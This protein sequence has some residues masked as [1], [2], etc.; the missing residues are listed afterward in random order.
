MLEF[1]IDIHMKRQYSAL[2]NFVKLVYIINGLHIN[3]VK[4]GMLN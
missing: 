1:L 3:C 2:E 4:C